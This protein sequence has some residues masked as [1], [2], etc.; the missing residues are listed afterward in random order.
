MKK[1]KKPEEINPKNEYKEIN[2]KNQIQ[3]RN[4]KKNLKYSILEFRING[5]FSFF[6]KKKEIGE[7]RGDLRENS[8][9][10]V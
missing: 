4:E 2:A 8:G 9:A 1:L 5:N 7:R 6:E 3:T 10:D